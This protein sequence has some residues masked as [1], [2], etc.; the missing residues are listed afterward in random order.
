MF[1]VT[2]KQK[3]LNDSNPPWIVQIENTAFC[4]RKCLWCPQSHLEFKPTDKMDWD[5]LE[6]IVE[7]LI[8][9]N[10]KN[11]IHP[12][13]NGEALTDK[14]F[15]DRVKYIKTNLP[16]CHLYIATNGDYI[17]KPHSFEDIIMAGVNYIQ[18]NHYDDN[19]SYLKDK[20]IP[21][22]E[23][24]DIGMLRT[25]FYNRA[26]NVKIASITQSKTCWFPGRKLYFNY[27]GD[28][29]ICCADWTFKDKIGNIREQSI[30]ELIASPK[31]RHYQE[32]LEQGWA[33]S[34]PLCSD[35]NLIQH[36]PMEV[37]NG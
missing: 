15:L 28:M 21:N 20:Y 32:C 2:T 18:C 26:G 5:T 31:I 30:T 33:D 10:Y 4:N 29:L 14:Y 11:R 13:G 16:E 9:I 3:T 37:A 12:Y 23:H 8:K 22:V 35:C 6:L 7:G 36:K 19:N 24:C 27:K 34:L 17:N 1:V 25:T